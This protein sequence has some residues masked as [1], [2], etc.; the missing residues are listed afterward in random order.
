MTRFTRVM[1]ALPREKGTAPR[2]GRITIPARAARHKMFVRGLCR[3]AFQETS[4][5]TDHACVRNWGTEG[6]CSG[7][8]AHRAILFIS[9]ADARA[10][11]EYHFAAVDRP[12]ARGDFPATNRPA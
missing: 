2:S 4:I 3:R 5:E 10:G 8:S 6:I 7:G 9:A 1:I 12:G 11:D